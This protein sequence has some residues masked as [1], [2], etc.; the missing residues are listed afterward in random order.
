MDI[1]YNYRPRE[2]YMK[3]SMLGGEGKSDVHS[4]KPKEIMT[5]INSSHAKPEIFEKGIHPKASG[6]MANCGDCSM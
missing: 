5:H 4:G 1:N 2:N 3:K 6:K